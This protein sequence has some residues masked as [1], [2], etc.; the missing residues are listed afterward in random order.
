[1]YKLK[2]EA[3]QQH[4]RLSELRREKI[5]APPRSGGMTSEAWVAEGCRDLEGKALVEEG[6]TRG[7]GGPAGQG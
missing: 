6:R 3:A 1:M 7:G 5:A 2:P 4:Q